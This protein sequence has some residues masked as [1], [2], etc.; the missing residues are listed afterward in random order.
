M[1]PLGLRILNCA[2]CRRVLLGDSHR[3]TDPDEV[4][5]AVEACATR[6]AM[7]FIDTRSQNLAA[8]SEDLWSRLA[9]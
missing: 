6:R 8:L 9:R 7:F 1:D 4:E 5:A 2:D 3:Y